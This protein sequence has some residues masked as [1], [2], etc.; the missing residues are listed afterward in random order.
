MA[1]VAETATRARVISNLESL[2]REIY[3]YKQYAF[4]VCQSKWITSKG[5]REIWENRPDQTTVH[6]QGNDN[7]NSLLALHSLHN[8]QAFLRLHALHQCLKD[9]GHNDEALR[10]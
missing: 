6:I 10:S 8:V 5:H 7:M 2:F 1:K 3:D 9:I 4:L